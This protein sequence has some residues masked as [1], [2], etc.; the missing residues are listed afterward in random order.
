MS[1]KS[2][3]CPALPLC[4]ATVLFFSSNILGYDISVG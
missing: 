1:F 4:E 2:G 3:D